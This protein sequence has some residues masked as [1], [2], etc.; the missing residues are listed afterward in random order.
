MA[1]SRFFDATTIG[2]T[3]IAE[4]PTITL[5]RSIHAR[6]PNPDFSKRAD[7]SLWIDDK[8]NLCGLNRQ[9]A[10]S[11][12]KDTELYTDVVEI[13]PRYIKR[14]LPPKPVILV[15]EMGLIL[16]NYDYYLVVSGNEIYKLSDELAY[17]FKKSLELAIS[18]GRNTLGTGEYSL[19]NRFWLFLSENFGL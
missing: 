9:N 10:V 2:M 18:E 6:M 17:D 11:Y 13:T 4:I 14:Y 5:K 19:S 1:T 7:D 16:K 12:D 8:F 3:R 15:F